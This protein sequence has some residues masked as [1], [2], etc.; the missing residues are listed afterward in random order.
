MCNSELERH[1]TH[2]ALAAVSLLRLL[3]MGIALRN[4]SYEL[5]TSQSIISLLR[6][7]G[8]GGAV[9]SPLFA[10]QSSHAYIGQGAADKFQA[11]GGKG[12]LHFK[13]T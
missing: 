2:Q 5:A 11:V 3:L 8:L 7:S 13:V 9:V 10:G 6:P 1:V 4:R 12:E